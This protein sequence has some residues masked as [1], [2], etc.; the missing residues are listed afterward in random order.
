MPPVD[1]NRSRTVP[2][3]V[4]KS[5][6]HS[7]PHSDPHSHSDPQPRESAHAREAPRGTVIEVGSNLTRLSTAQAL[8]SVLEDWRRDVPEVNPDAFSKWIVHVELSGRPMN[9]SMRLAQARRLAGNGDFGAQAE[10]VTFCCENGYKTLIPVSDVRARTQG[11]RRQAHTPAPT[12]AELE[13]R[14]AARGTR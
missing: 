10:V 9:P 2:Q 12:T 8:A 1:G 5:D 4:S 11:M 3:T 14:E 6:S 7:D 13:A